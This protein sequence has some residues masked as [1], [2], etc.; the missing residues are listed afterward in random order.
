MTPVAVVL[1]MSGVIS[2]IVGAARGL[3]AVRAGM[4]PQ[5]DADDTPRADSAVRRALPSVV[6]LCIAV[7]G[8]VLASVG[9]AIAR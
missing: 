5:V 8:L 9:I 7:Y 1:F 2:L 4:A 6:W 3:A